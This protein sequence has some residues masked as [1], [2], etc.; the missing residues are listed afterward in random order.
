MIKR[1]ISYGSDLQQKMD[2]HFPETWGSSTQVVFLIHGGG[3]VS[4]S[5]E[6]FEMAAQMFCQQGFVVVNLSHRLIDAAG[7]MH[8]PPFHRKSAVTILDQV[9][10]LHR[11]V[12]CFE[13]WSSSLGV[14][15]KNMFMAGHSAGAVLAMLYVQGT[16]NAD[17]AIRASGNWAGLT[18]LSIPPAQIMALMDPRWKELLYRATGK[19]AIPENRLT[20]EKVSPFHVALHHVPRPHISV[21]PR[22][23]IIFGL[24]LE[25]EL[26][27]DYTVKYHQLLKEKGAPEKLVVIEDE[28]HNFFTLDQSWQ[29]V[30]D[31]TSSFFSSLQQAD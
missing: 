4:G 10:D 13:E 8:L 25:K 1:N 24:P 18:N 16:L 27:Y 12:T 3:F 14:G 22:N 11:A 2:L 7:L 21:F 17:G 28:S 23:N 15:T 19:E 9:E 31:E 29:R 26:Q 30:I 20:Y 6:E 5:K